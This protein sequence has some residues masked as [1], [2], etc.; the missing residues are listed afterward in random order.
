[1]V[2]IIC[3]ELEIQSLTMKMQGME[4]AGGRVA[5]TCA[6]HVRRCIGNKR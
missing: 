4:E 1:M 3:I 6:A 5:G 2:V